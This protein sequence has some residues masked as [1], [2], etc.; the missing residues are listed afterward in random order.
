MSKVNIKKTMMIV[1]VILLSAMWKEFPRVNDYYDGLVHVYFFDV[2]QGDAVLIKDASRRLF[3]ID[4][5]PGESVSY[6]LSSVLPFWINRIDYVIATHPHADHIAGLV[7]VLDRYEIGCIEYD[8][9]N[10]PISKIEEKLRS[11]I[12]ERSIQSGMD[13]LNGV[14]D[15]HTSSL[16]NASKNPNLNSIVSVFSYKEFDVLFTGD[17]E[18]PSQGNILPS[19]FKDVEIMKVPHHGSKDSFYLPMLLRVKP[20]VA[21]I[22]AGRNNRY[23]LP[24]EAVIEG[25]ENL[26]IKVLRTDLDGTVQVVSDGL[27]WQVVE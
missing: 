8:D 3:L 9:T 1:L 23:H 19:L 24:N 12:I 15:V 17:A 18:N 2:G 22:S 6:L 26:G 21:I 11:V 14:M 7:Y 13:C 20:E 4:G 25:Y 16:R 27:H 5:G 10:L